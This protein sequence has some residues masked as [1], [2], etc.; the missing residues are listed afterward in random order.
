MV[1]LN[2]FVDSCKIVLFKSLYT[3]IDVKPYTKK[4]ENTDCHQRILHMKF[5]SIYPSYF[6][7]FHTCT[8][9][10]HHL[11][12][13]NWIHT[14]GIGNLPKASN[15]KQKEKMEDTARIQYISTCHMR[16]HT[17]VVV[18]NNASSA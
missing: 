7:K 9:F 10:I 18:H 13:L 6:R 16:S 15:S 5:C 8:S 3:Q 11:F 17:K 12:R 4:K 1:S 2:C 14:V